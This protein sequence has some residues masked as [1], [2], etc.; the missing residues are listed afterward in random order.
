MRRSVS[1]R[2]QISLPG[3]AGCGVVTVFFVD[4]DSASNFGALND[5]A[6]WLVCLAMLIRRLE[7]F[8]ILIC[9]HVPS[10]REPTS[11]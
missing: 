2:W 7:V 8:P 9:Y 4:G 11:L 10:E 3:R 1:E 5:A 6:K